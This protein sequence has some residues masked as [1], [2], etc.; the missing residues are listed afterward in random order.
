MKEGT[1]GRKEEDGSRSAKG[2]GRKI[3]CPK[4]GMTGTNQEVVGYGREYCYLLSELI[5][6]LSTI[7]YSRNGCGVGKFF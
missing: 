5:I 1:G 3:I 6:S 7:T 4:S 2:D